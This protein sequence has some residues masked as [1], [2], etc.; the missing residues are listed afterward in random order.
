MTTK[1]RPSW[2]PIKSAEKSFLLPALQCCGPTVHALKMSLQA[3]RCEHVV[4]ACMGTCN[5][6]YPKKKQSSKKNWSK[7]WLCLHAWVRVA[8]TVRNLQSPPRRSGVWRVAPKT[9]Q[10]EPVSNLTH[11]YMF[12]HVCACASAV[13]RAW[14]ANAYL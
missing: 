13:A 3:K 12:V 9:N 2:R 7:N 4:L 6:T 1:L 10:T 11:T 8:L 14:R 5:N